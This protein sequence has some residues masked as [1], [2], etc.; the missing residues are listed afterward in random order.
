MFDQLN[1]AESVLSRQSAQPAAEYEAQLRAMPGY[2]LKAEYIIQLG[3][4]WDALP[5][6]RLENA[7]VALVQHRQGEKQ[8]T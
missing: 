7:I 1:P 5:R 3:K 2:E 6:P 4:S 8:P